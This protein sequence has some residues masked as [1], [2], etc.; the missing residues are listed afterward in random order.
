MTTTALTTRGNLVLLPGVTEPARSVVAP[1]RPRS[2]WRK[3]WWWPM[4]YRMASVRSLQKRVKQLESALVVVG[5]ALDPQC[6]AV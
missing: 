2:F 5:V 3:P 6:G 4:R 1:R